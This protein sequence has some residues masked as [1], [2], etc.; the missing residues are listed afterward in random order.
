MEKTYLG[1]AKK[2]FLAIECSRFWELRRS[3]VVWEV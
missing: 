2:L 3:I 1:F